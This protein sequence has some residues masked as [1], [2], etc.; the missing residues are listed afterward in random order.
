SI[1]ATLDE[2][3]QEEIIYGRTPS[4]ALGGA[5]AHWSLTKEFFDTRFSEIQEEFE[6]EAFEISLRSKVQR[7][8][9]FL[10][11]FEKEVEIVERVNCCILGFK[12]FAGMTAKEINRVLHVCKSKDFPV[13]IESRGLFLQLQA[14]VR[15]L[16]MRE[17]LA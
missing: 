15:K 9:S 6:R 2:I 8:N 13:K 7:R 17:S 16:S 4:D 12:D 14:Y 10:H 5:F 1:F 11:G 3:V